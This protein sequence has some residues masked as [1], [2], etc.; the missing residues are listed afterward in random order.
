MIK[1]VS[2]PEGA[3]AQIV[4]VTNWQEELKR[5]VPVN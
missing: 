2:G 1:P 5:L 3:R 4:V